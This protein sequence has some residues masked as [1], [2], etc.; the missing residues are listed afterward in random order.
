MA[1]RL[2]RRRALAG[3]FVLMLIGANEHIVIAHV[4]VST[5]VSAFQHANIDLRFGPLNYIFSSNELHRW[6][7]S[8]DFTYRHALA[9]NLECLAALVLFLALL[10]LVWRRFGAA[11][12]IFA[13][14]SLALPLSYPGKDFPLLSLPRFGLVVFP[15]F[16]ALAVLGESPR[17]HALILSVSALLLGIAIVQWVTFQWVA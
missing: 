8:A 6:H 3:G 4:T 10:P 7:H 1:A 12:G 11:Y 2:G 5:V 9:V 15:F 13:V 17:V 16:L 14:V